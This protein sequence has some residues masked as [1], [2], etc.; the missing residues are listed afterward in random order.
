MDFI[1]I[2]IIA[3]III[4]LFPLFIK[5]IGCLIRSIVGLILAVIVFI[6]LTKLF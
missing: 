1:T 6:L 2:L 4:L 3:V 5:G